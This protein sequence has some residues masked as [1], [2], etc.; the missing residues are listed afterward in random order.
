MLYQEWLKLFSLDEYK[1]G[2]V[3]TQILKCFCDNNVYFENIINEENR[4]VK[5]WIFKL[6]NKQINIQTVAD[7]N[8]CHEILFYDDNAKVKLSKALSEFI[9]GFVS[10]DI[11]IV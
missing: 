1:F 10:L 4:E 9:T 7:R 5:Y 11:S 6:R 2:N 8:G 3:F